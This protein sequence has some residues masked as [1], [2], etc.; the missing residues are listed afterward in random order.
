[1]QTG[2]DNLITDIT[3]INVGNSQCADLKSGVTVLTAATPLR[4]AVDVRGGAPGTRETDLLAPDKLVETVDAIVLSG[5]SAF[6][7]DA[8]SGVTD[9]LAAV[10][11]GF[12]VGPATVPI[13]SAAILF[14]LLNGGNKSWTQN[15]YRALGE[16]A[17]GNVAGHFELGSVGAGTGANC[18]DFKGGLGSASLVTSEGY[19]V[20]ALVAVNP[21][22]SVCLP[23]TKHFWAAPF[24]LNREFGG[25]G[26]ATAAPVI[27][28]HDPRL[29]TPEQDNPRGNTT[30]AIVACDADLQVADLQRLAIAAQDGLARAIFPS[31]TPLDGD[32]VFAVC[33]A[34]K[35]VTNPVA[36]QYELGHAA[37]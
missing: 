28:T 12:Q 16:Q 14:D 32:T 35:P 11:R 24:E 2:V 30:I 13:V 20:G 34:A 22:G 21:R 25:A 10:G 18:A 31:H 23:Q 15:P 36:T 8:A 4:A 27:I 1:M 19:T 6:G 7:L 33:T 3:G 5:G 26:M 17:L 9:A 29:T 37:S